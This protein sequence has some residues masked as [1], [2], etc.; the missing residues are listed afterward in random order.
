MPAPSKKRLS[1]DESLG[2]ARDSLANKRKEDHQQAFDV[3][4]E[5]NRQLR[6]ELQHEKMLKRELRA[7]LSRAEK[8]VELS[9]ELPSLPHLGKGQT[10]CNKS[11]AIVCRVLQFARNY[12]GQHA[13]EWTSSV[14]GIKRQTL[15][16]YETETNLDLAAI[17]V[18][19]G[20]LAY[21]LPPCSTAPQ[22]SFKDRVVEKIDE[23]GKFPR[24][25][26]ENFFQHVINVE[27]ELD[28]FDHCNIDLNPIM[29]DDDH[30]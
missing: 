18:E 14:T 2:K 29:D 22:K 21:K 19:E 7:A 16:S 4:N 5:E 20:T 13:V 27:D 12:C 9:S 23:E 30:E 26:I 1:L 6:A 3:L 17:S 8:R 24:R 10:L 11:K 15:R 28:A 25:H